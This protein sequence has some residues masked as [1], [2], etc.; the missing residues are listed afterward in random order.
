MSL[1]TKLNLPDSVCVSGRFY[2]VK[3]GHTY[4]FR[5]AEIIDDEDATFDDFD[6]LFDGDAPEDKKEAFNA[7]LGFYWKKKEIPRVM[8]EATSERII[9]Y[10]I[11]ADLIYAAIMQCYGI[12]LCAGEVH[13]H[14]VRALI[15]GLTGTK[16]NEIMSYRCSKPG[17][18][19]TMAK[20]KR[21]WALP[22]KESAENRAARERFNKLL[23]T[24][25]E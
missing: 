19:K 14:K 11:D 16:F 9:D 17:K 21:I 13:W 25:S 15:A 24:K 18:D 20:L 6:F 22:I 5:F 12:D 8:G 1:L 7:F 2:K 10:S 23:E 4:W 3:T